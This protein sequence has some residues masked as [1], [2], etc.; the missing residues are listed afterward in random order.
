MYYE[1]EDELELTENQKDDKPELTE[2]QIA[3]EYFKLEIKGNKFNF[4]GLQVFLLF[5]IFFYI[6]SFIETDTTLLLA[7]IALFFFPAGFA[8][9]VAGNNHQILGRKKQTS[10]MSKKYYLFNLV[11]LAIIVV[12]YLAAVIFFSVALAF[13]LGAH[14]ILLNVYS[15]S[16]IFCPVLLFII[17]IAKIFALKT[18]LDEYH[19]VYEVNFKK[20]SHHLYLLPFTLF[21]IFTSI[22]TSISVEP[23]WVHFHFSTQIIC[24][25]LTYMLLLKVQSVIQN[26]TSI[27]PK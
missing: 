10:S 16:L 12:V 20:I 15:R 18:I 23:I 4:F 24:L 1:K 3:Q 5:T 19:E 2:S 9:F 17:E 25:V 7:G 22:M 13:D 6:G 8:V 21:L 11:P 27:Y 26:P 14:A